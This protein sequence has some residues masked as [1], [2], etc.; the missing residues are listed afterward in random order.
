M[1]SYVPSTEDITL[2]SVL[3]ESVTSPSL[4][5]FA[6][7]PASLYSLPRVKVMLLPPIILMEGA[8]V[9]GGSGITS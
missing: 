3:I 1:T 9:S 4:S 8:V 7:A 2:S 6:V 5:S